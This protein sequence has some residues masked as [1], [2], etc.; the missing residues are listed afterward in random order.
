MRTTKASIATVAFFLLSFFLSTTNADDA[1]FVKPANSPAQP[2]GWSGGNVSDEFFEITGVGQEIASDVS[3]ASLALEPRK[4]YRFSFKASC[5]GDGAGDVAPCGVGFAHYDFQGFPEREKP[6]KD[7]SFV[8]FASERDAEARCS[9]GQWNSTRTFRFAAPK[10]NAVQPVYRLIERQN[11]QGKTEASREREVLLLG[12]GESIDEFGVYRFRALNAAKEKTNCD[13]PLYSVDSLFNTSRWVFSEG[14]SVVYRFALNPAKLRFDANA[15]S[16]EF[17]PLPPVPIVSAHFSLEVGCYEAG[18]LVVEASDDGENWREVGRS[19]WNGRLVSALDPFFAGRVLDSFFVRLRGEQNLKNDGCNF[20]ISDFTF[21]MFTAADKNGFVGEGATFFADLDPQDAPISDAS[22]APDATLWG[23]EPATKESGVERFYALSDDGKIWRAALGSKSCPKI[24]EKNEDGAICARYVVAFRRPAS[25]NKRLSFAETSYFRQR[26]TREIVGAIGNASGVSLSWAVPDVQIPRDPTSVEIR[27]SNGKPIQI[28]APK[29]DVESFQIAVRPTQG[30]LR[31]VSAQ[32]VGDLKGANGASIPASNVKLRYAYYHFVSDPTDE[33]GAAGWYPDAL[34]PIE[35]GADGEGAPLD[36]ASGQNLPIWTTVKIPCD[37]APGVYRGTLRLTAKSDDETASELAL[38]VLVPF[39][40]VVWDFALPETPILESGYGID[41]LALFAYC[42]AK[43]EEDKRALLNFCWKSYS[44]HR[45][46]PI[47]ATFLDPI[48]VE[49]RPNDE[50]PCCVVDTTA[51][52][53]EVERLIETYRFNTLRVVLER[54]DGTSVP[55]DSPL[56]QADFDSPRWQAAFADYGRKIQERFR[57]LGLLDVLICDWYDEPTR[58]DYERVAKSFG[59]LKRYLPDVRTRLTEEP[60]DELTRLLDQYGGKIDVWT[61]ISPSYS[62]TEARKRREKGEKSWIYVCTGPKA[63]YCC[64]FIDHP[65]IELRIWH[66]QAFERDI[67][68]TLIWSTTYW[69]SV[70]PEP[71]QAQ[72][73][74]LDPQA[75]VSGTAREARRFWGNGDGRFLYPPL[76]AATPG[77]NDGK[78]IIEPPNESMRW[79]AL[80][81]GAEDY[82][83]LSMLKNLAKER[84]LS[85]EQREDVERLLDFTPITTSLTE[86]STDPDVLYKR[87]AEIAS[88]IVALMRLPISEKQ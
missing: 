36:V 16:G 77:R 88:A 82:D 5:F 68:G 63:P 54:I 70:D 24:D 72:N 12:D 34:V 35:Q 19:E 43:T 87:R 17:A 32:V 20:Q 4:P 1:S 57:E 30:G 59:A 21:D 7:Y 61:P 79:E 29:N 31:D 39:E 49:W 83:M 3:S 15:P 81:E 73:P 42:N 23:F 26:C 41:E 67:V 46:S 38:D 45:L 74:Y 78:P 56:V 9:L 25:L 48:K 52:E 76:R 84:D 10:L 69:T 14:S 80:R 33:L 22:Q 6:E 13:R 55:S 66:W 11:A 86:F 18:R 28:A 27:S 2:S 65:T 85:P 60:S 47:E 51:F 58:E 37:A 64:E 53:K 71:G 50:P 44:E 40:T 62:E 8:F 75:Y